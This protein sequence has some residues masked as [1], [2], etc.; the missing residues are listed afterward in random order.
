MTSIVVPIPLSSQKIQ[1]TI[2]A[3][4]A[5]MTK[6]QGVRNG[7]IFEKTLKTIMATKN[8][9]RRD[10]LI[11]SRILRGDSP[12]SATLLVY[13]ERHDCAVT[14]RTLQRDLADIR[15]NFDI[16]IIYDPYRKGW[17]IDPET[18]G[19]FEKTLYFMELAETSDLLL[20]G[21][22]RQRDLLR[23]LVTS[24]TT[25][26]KGIELLP[27]LLRAIHGRE[28]V[29]FDHT[30][31]TT[32]TTTRYEV[33]PY[34]LKEF[35]GRWYLFAYVP[36][37]EAFRTFGLDRIDSLT[38]TGEHFERTGGREE[39][40]RKFDRVY[41]LVYEPGQQKDAPVECVRVRFHNASMLRHLAA[42]P[43]HASQRIEGDTAE[44]QVIVNPELENK[45]LSYGE[46]AEVLAPE[47]LRRR[48]AR[49]LRETLARY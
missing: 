12:S 18:A 3:F 34:L 43:L 37:K 6:R 23:Y 38:P 4:A 28:V 48:I 40:A 35:D 11:I 49:R 22:R 17:T 8:N 10:Y 1:E 26:P 13:L 47:S 44:W 42:L 25:R 32:G 5:G 20:S 41:G 39:T 24:P 9:I 21:V 27:S 19:D 31:Y 45:I 16:D 7:L 29:A 2:S 33:H 46:Y 30:N 15:S 36:E 14:N